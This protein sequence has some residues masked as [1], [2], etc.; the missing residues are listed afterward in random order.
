MR[1]CLLVPLAL[2]ALT[3]APV[4]QA[5]G[6]SVTDCLSATEAAPKLRASHKLREARKQLL[7]CAA[8]TCPAEIRADCTHGID[9][10]NATLPTVVFTVKSGTGQELSAV[11]VTMDGEV[12]AQQLDGSALT[13]DP[14]SHSFK[15]EM[16]GQ[17]PVT[18]TFILHE[19]D[20]GRRETVV[21]GS[22]PSAGPVAV[23]PVPVAAAPVVAP[24]PPPPPVVL[25]PPP[26]ETT[27]AVN[28]S[29][30]MSGQRVLGIVV[31]SVG[32]AGLAV[33]G[34]FGGLA[35]SSYS[36]ANNECPSHSGCSPQAMN[37][38]SSASTLA[39]VSTAGIIAGGVL[40]VGG[41]TVFLTAPK[42]SAATVGL[43][44]R[45]GGLALTGGF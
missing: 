7:V 21:M 17:A 23:V 35:A 27:A 2:A 30:A 44:V 11:K 19:G 22:A 24:P 29:G 42:H 3:L 8:P 33:G 37:D 18:Q 6:P 20:K 38:R 43:E 10:V 14:G 41:L 34:I 13:L 12:V 15:F 31:G 40:V 45:P 36:T 16:A 39:S 1:L 25:P 9:E 26:P 32:V 28:A 4:V 5:A